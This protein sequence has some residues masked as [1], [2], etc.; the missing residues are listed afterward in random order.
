MNKKIVFSI[1]LLLSTNSHVFYAAEEKESSQ[2]AASIKL[3]LT[4]LRAEQEATYLAALIA[5]NAICEKE[6]KEFEA[7][8][9]TQKELA[10]AIARKEILKTKRTNSEGLYTAQVAALNKEIEALT[11]KINALQ[12]AL[13]ESQANYTAAEA[14]YKQQ[15]N[16]LNKEIQKL[17]REESKTLNTIIQHQSETAQAQAAALAAGIELNNTKAKRLKLKGG[18]SWTATFGLAT[19]TDKPVDLTG[20]KGYFPKKA[21]ALPGAHESQQNS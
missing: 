12:Q 1:M 4:R 18:P 17:R 7:L 9:T 2:D 16:Q 8:A 3:E 21:V 6:S 10:A 19:D 5:F 20:I 13:T 11:Q 14:T 15:R